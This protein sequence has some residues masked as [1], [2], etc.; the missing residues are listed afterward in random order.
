[1]STRV[2]LSLLPA[3]FLLSYITSALLLAA[4]ATYRR[5]ETLARL[6]RCLELSDIT[7]RPEG[8]QR[9]PSERLSLLHLL[10]LRS[11]TTGGTAEPLR[12]LRRRAAQYAFRPLPV[13]PP[14]HRVLT[15]FNL[16]GL[17]Q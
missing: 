5:V 14:L 11:T 9:W 3:P 6:S 12:P 17:L 2:L 10:R 8:T 16:T 13:P 15:C 7:S 4:A 1:M